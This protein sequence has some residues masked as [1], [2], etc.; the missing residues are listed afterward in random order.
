MNLN[1][2]ASG[3]VCNNNEPSNC[4]TYGRLYNWATAMGLHYSCNSS[5]CS[6]QINPKHKGICPTDWHIP[7]DADWNTLMDAVGGSSVAGK[8]LKTSEWGGE[9]AFGFS[10]L[11]GGSGD[12]NGDVVGVLYIEGHGR[13]WSA[14][15]KDSNSAYGRSMYNEPGSES[16]DWSNYDKSHLFSV[17]CLK[18]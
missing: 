9:D 7:S 13:W 1:Y 6:G 17:R 15:E 8:K 14:S 10:A 18:D 3:S 11:L 12:Y 16:A 2:N 4:T 5:T